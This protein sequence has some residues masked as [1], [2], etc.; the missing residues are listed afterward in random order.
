MLGAACGGSDSPEPAGELTIAFL[1][2][3]QGDATL[4]TVDGQR[5]LV[6]GGRSTDRIEERLTALGVEDIDAVVSTH[7][8]ADHI[9]GLAHVL[10]RY[11]VEDI[12][13]GGGTSE[14][15][16]FDEW[17]ALVQ[18]EGA[19]IVTARRGDTIPLGGLE[20][21]VLHPTGITGDSN[22]DSVVLEL[23]CGAVDVLLMG[24][25]TSESERSMLDAGVIRDTDVL[26]VGHHRLGDVDQPG[27]PRRL[28][29]RSTR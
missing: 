24:D 17:M 25:A 29:R 1:D 15:E 10:K 22:A 8:D 7:P 3:A 6:D 18:D 21:N 11:E 16:T 13:L 2:V 23:A 4:I 26:K 12:Y 9:A 20:L 27:V 14:S 28:P 5:L 19:D